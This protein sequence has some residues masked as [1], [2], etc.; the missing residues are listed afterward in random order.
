MFVPIII[1]Y[2]APEWTLATSG[3]YE[4]ALL[5][6]TINM[7][8]KVLNHRGTNIKDHITKLSS[9]TVDKAEGTDQL[10]ISN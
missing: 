2:H 6:K 8:V 9:F 5:E 10:G 1:W 3:N 4:F 7:K